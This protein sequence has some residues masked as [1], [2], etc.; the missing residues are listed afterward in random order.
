MIQRIQTIHLI[1]AAIVGIAS[2]II[3]LGHPFL[4]DAG[5]GTGVV[6]YANAVILLLGSVVS[7]RSIFLYRNR[8]RQM[9]TVTLGC[10]I[11]AAGYALIVVCAATGVTRE[12]WSSAVFYLPLLCIFFNIM[13]HKRIKY[14]DNLVRSADRLR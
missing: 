10:A 1:C 6:H 7:F 11:F 8:P 13:A 5:G 9:K 2:I 3:G 12:P 4:T 14:D